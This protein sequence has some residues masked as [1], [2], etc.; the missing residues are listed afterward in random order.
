DATCEAACLAAWQRL[1][2]V[3]A[4]ARGAVGGLFSDGGLSRGSYKRACVP[5]GPARMDAYLR[6]ELPG[7]KPFDQLNKLRASVVARGWKKG[8]VPRTQQ[9]LAGGGGVPER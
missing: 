3:W 6:P 5:T 2:V 9:A 4:G 1:R 8:A 7:L